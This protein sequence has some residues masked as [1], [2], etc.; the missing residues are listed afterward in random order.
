MAAKR[1]LY[2]I[3]NSAGTYIT[4]WKDVVSDL[5]F[6]TAVFSGVGE[7]NIVLAR[8]IKSFGEN[9]D[10]AFNN[11]V[12]VYAFDADAPTGT[13]VA[14]G[15]ITRYTP[16]LS[17]RDETL[18]VTCLGYVHELTF[19]PYVSG[20]NLRFTKSAMDPSLMFKDV[21]DISTA[22]GGHADYDGSS[23]DLTG[24]S[25][26]YEFNALTCFDALKK[27]IELCPSEW[28]WYIGADNVAYL[29]QKAAT[30][31]HTFT[32]GKSVVALKAEKNIEDVVNRIYFTGGIV[33]TTYIDQSQATQDTTQAVGTSAAQ[34]VGQSF[35][36]GKGA[37]SGVR[38][39]KY[40]DNGTPTI[41]LSL[42]IYT[43]LN[44]SP[45][46]KLTSR[47]ITTEWAALASAAYGDFEL[48]SQDL[49]EGATYWAVLEVSAADASNY[50]NTRRI[51]AGAY[52]S[53]TCKIY[54]GSAWSAPGGDLYFATFYPA[55]LF[56]VY[57]DTV[58][59]GL[60]GLQAMFKED[61]RIT[62]EDSMDA[63]ADSILDI[64]VYPEVRMTLK[65][66]DNANNARGYDIETIKP[67][68]TCYIRNLVDSDYSKWDIATWDVSYWDRSL[69]NVQELLAQI[70][71]VQ[72]N[73]DF[74][75][76]EVSTRPPRIAETLEEIDRDIRAAKVND[77]PD[78]P[79][80]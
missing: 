11:Q 43:D 31:T 14:T 28:Y 40:A 29:K 2:K 64:K 21:F 1:F 42:A 57:E 66:A 32:L 25:E 80:T 10:V 41:K 48:P 61:E 76:I 7:F 71:S 34:K 19:L 65:V 52:A 74:V 77:N 3:Y 12:K 49:V 67:G 4:T 39:M 56:K 37:I 6:K 55:N 62:N 16:D 18:T 53:G 58:S 54:N 33:P 5:Q 15:R 24:L 72:Y 46:D 68:D 70:Q 26:T 73:P 47:E 79:S 60:Y 8:T 23:V 17:G 50:F 75:I 20:T 51:N 36:A 63:I 38:L 45:N 9:S 59:Q 13:L 69:G 22:A 27:I 35:V 44:G 78:A 30:A